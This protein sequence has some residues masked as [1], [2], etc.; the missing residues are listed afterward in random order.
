MVQDSI[1]DHTLSNTFK[2]RFDNP[3]GGLPYE[4]S[5]TMK[6]HFVCFKSHGDRSYM[7]RLRNDVSAAYFYKALH[8]A[9]GRLSVDLHYFI[10]EVI[11][12]TTEAEEAKLLNSMWEE[13]CR[14]RDL[15]PDV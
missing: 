10:M 14:W 2:V 12:K 15:N 8:E 4:L 1:D 9:L 13:L 7:F 5:Q 3:V 11:M 6:E